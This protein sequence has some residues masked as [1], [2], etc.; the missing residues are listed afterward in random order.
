MIK[1]LWSFF[2]DHCLVRSAFKDTNEMFRKSRRMF[3]SVADFFITGQ[4]IEYDIYP[5]DKEINRAEITVRRKLLEHLAVNPKQEL[6]FS[7]ILTTVIKDIERIGDYSKNIYELHEIFQPCIQLPPYT[8]TLREITEQVKSSFDL[9]VEAFEKADSEKA[10]QVLI[11][12]GRI[13]PACEKVIRSLAEN[14]D[15]D[16][17]P[18]VTLVLYARYMKRVSA[19]LANIMTSINQPF[20][21]IG[22]FRDQSGADPR[23]SK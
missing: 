8:D 1:K 12:H 15:L 18:V 22:F 9:A 6:V 11:H 2:N 23:S 20:D 10:K 16:T 19:H 5:A 3:V 14:P 17:R 13:N 7:L 4:E 21:N